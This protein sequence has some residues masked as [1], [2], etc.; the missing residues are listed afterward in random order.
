MTVRVFRSAL[1]PEIFA[2]AEDE[3]KLPPQFRPWHAEGNAALPVS[4]AGL[5]DEV[6]NAIKNQGYYLAQKA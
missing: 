5:P 4:G 2:F 1:L 3:A 6:E